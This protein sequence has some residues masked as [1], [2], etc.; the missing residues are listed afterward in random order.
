MA[1]GHCRPI[2]ESKTMAGHIGPFLVLAFCLSQGLRDVYFGHVFQRV[3]FFAVIL[4]A[5]SISTLGFGAI[6]A[7][8]T[9]AELGKLRGQLRTVLVINLT[10]ALAW[11][12]YFFAL[13][14][15]EPSIV[16]TVHSG[17]G[18][19]TVIALAACGARIA[20]PRAMRRGERF[21]HAGIAL[22]LVALGA[23]VLSGH[24]GL[25]G[26]SPAASLAALL[27]VAV[28][29][30]SITVS[31]L[32]CKRLHDAGVSAEAVT[33]VRYLALILLA[34]GVVAGYGG[35]AGIGGVAELATVS[36]AATALIVLPLFALQVG[37]ARTAP[38]SAHVIRSLGPVCVFVLQQ[39]D[40]RLAYSTPT[41]VCIAAYSACAIACNIAHGWHGE[42]AAD[43][44]RPL[45]R[46]AD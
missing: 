28:S 42:P 30:A 26:T 23:V 32:Y 12:C 44:A 24:S 31:L 20:Q 41:L 4:V 6:T 2:A 29:G 45:P 18:P 9:P 8:R 27:L 35:M 33:T 15:L 34:A 36:L 17:I 10:T 13:T 43:L 22:S 25:R 1:G 16:N 5:F 38:L 40:G 11:S 39:L 19:L 21:A 37:I 7:I 3:D 14:H 46:H